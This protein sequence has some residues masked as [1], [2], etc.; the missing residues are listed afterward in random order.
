MAGG[1]TLKMPTE[2]KRYHTQSQF[3]ADLA[4]ALGGYVAEKII[5]GDDQVST[6]PSSDLKNA[7]KLAYSMVTQY[8]M[9]V[10]GPRTFG[11]QEEMIFMGREMRDERDYSEKTAE[12]I[13]K[14]VKNLLVEAEKRAREILT[15][16]RERVE[17]MVA[18]LMDK[19]TIEEADIKEI[20]V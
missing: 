12:E 9:S 1:Y 2:D 14:E 16:Q 17:K 19:E 6:G 4:M 8:G 7:T 5:F 18:M 20:M 3:K 13:D 15:S 11:D 10:L